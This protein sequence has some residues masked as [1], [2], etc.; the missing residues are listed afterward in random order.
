MKTYQ[1][2]PN[3]LQRLVW[4][5]LRLS[6][7]LFCSLKIEG[8]ENVRTLRGNA[9]VA[10]NHLSE[11]DPLLLVACLPFFSRH[12]PLFFVS[13]EK[14]Y[15]G[16]RNIWKR[17]L[18]GGTFFTMMGAY[19]AY[20]GLHN[21]RLALR[22][23]LAI[24]ADGK[25][26]CIFPTGTRNPDHKTL[27]AKGGVTHLAVET[28]LPILPVLIQGVEHLTLR[29]F[30]SGKRNITVTFG[31]PLYAKDIGADAEEMIFTENRNDYETAAAVLMDEIATLARAPLSRE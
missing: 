24:I 7:S 4:A 17:L 1:I 15:Y 29:S 28:G 10:S 23:H 30:L 3:I 18:Y 12:L 19:P 5:P 27:A 9:I 22:H 14:T 26:V 25:S 11:L 20:S 8:I 31:K 16:N 6:L 2:L 13:R 21:Y